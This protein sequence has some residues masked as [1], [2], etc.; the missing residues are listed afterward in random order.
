[1]SV[2]H[3]TF[4]VASRFLWQDTVELWEHIPEVTL[5]LHIFSFL[6][7]LHHLGILIIRLN[8]G[9]WDGQT[10]VSA[11]VFLICSI[12]FYITYS[13]SAFRISRN[14]PH[15]FFRGAFHATIY[16][17]CCPLINAVFNAQV[18]V[19]QHLY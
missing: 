13:W 1:M 4:Y 17:G 15:P 5:L 11:L 2:V 14:K 8:N 6:L 16:R 3:N 18:N 9:A 7:S 19:G 10:M 12:G